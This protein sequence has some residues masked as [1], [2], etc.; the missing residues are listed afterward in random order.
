MSTIFHS[1]IDRQIKHGNWTLEYMLWIFL[2]VYHNDWDEYLMT[3]EFAYN[4][5]IQASIKHSSSFFNSSQ[6][7]ICQ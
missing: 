1:Q 6:H 4:V 5:S 3:L 7:L 2:A